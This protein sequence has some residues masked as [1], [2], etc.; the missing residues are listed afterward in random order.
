MIVKLVY[1]EN[2]CRR[3]P[4]ALLSFQKEA[5]GKREHVLVDGCLDLRVQPFRLSAGDSEPTCITF[6]I[7]FRPRIGE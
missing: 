3:M 2:G 7:F 4:Q 6:L 1:C 5:T